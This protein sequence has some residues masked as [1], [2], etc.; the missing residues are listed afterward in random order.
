MASELDAAVFNLPPAEA[1]RALEEKGYRIS[2]DWREVWKQEHEK[3]FAVAKATRLDILADIRTAVEDA[4]VNG[5]LLRDFSKE[6]TPILQAK[7]WWGEKVVRNPTTGEE[8]LVQLGSAARLRVIYETNLRMAQASGRYE[9]MERLKAARPY[10]RYVALGNARPEHKAWHGT[11]LPL[12][13]PW[14]ETHMPPNGWGCRCAM[15]QLSARDLER[16]GYSLADVAPAVELVE[17][18]NKRTGQ[19][20]LVPKGIDPGFDLNPG[21]A[22]LEGRA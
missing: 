20:E 21:K 10:G 12:D 14:W 18:T 8:E 9:R 22:R 17:W 1:V 13:D 16:Y 6:L 19:V 2:W 11:V 4:L 15:Q 7:G 5:T 3:A